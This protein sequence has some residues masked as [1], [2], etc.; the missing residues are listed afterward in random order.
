MILMLFDLCH[1]TLKVGVV[2][3][4][5]VLCRTY[6][7]LISQMKGKTRLQ[8][9]VD[10]CGGS[11]FDGC[12][13]FDECHKAKN[14]VPGKEAQST[15]VSITFPMRWCSCCMHGHAGTLV[16]RALTACSLT[17]HSRSQLHSVG[18]NSLYS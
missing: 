4:W 18:S 15:K 2:R 12:I 8:Q 10:W 11:T 6:T 1:T 13:V 7:T 9:V 17:H 16:S 14:F 5:A 3:M